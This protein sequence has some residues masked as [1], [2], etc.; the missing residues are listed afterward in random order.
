MCPVKG[1]SI[2]LQAWTVPKGFI[3]L[4]LPDFKKIGTCRVVSPTHRPPL[5]PKEIFLVLVR[6]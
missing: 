1:K 3:R 5:T 2:S 6:G 4:R